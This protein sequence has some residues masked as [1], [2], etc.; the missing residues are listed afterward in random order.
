VRDETF[1]VCVPLTCAQ[2]RL[3]GL[4]DLLM[5]QTMTRTLQTG[6]LQLALEGHII[7][8]QAKAVQ[9]N[10]QALTR[11]G[12]RLAV[13]EPTLSRVS[14][15]ELEHLPIDT[16]YLDAGFCSE[17]RTEPNPTQAQNAVIALARALGMRVIKPH[18]HLGSVS[19]PTADTTTNGNHA[20]AHLS[21]LS[22]TELLALLSRERISSAG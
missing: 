16:L 3:P 22:L 14:V 8:W 17:W 4:A 15:Q 2:W 19:A 13:S 11:L 21:T 10:L 20:T 18:H 6:A 5:R 12:I 1:T 7:D 9:E